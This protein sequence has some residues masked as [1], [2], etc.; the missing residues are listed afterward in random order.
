M[1]LLANPAQ[2]EA[3]RTIDGP[4][5]IISCPGSGK[6]TTLV[7]RIHHMIE[8]GV[9]PESIL[10]VTFT[11]DAAEGMA[12]K[13]KELFSSNPGVTFA[14]IHSLC[15]T[16]LKQEG[17]CAPRDFLPEEKKIGFLADFIRNRYRTRDSWEIAAAA[18][19]AISVLKNNGQNPDSINEPG[20]SLEMLTKA[21]EAYE[22]WR[23][24]SGFVDFD[25]MLVMCHEAL[26]DNPSMLEKY[27]DMF[28]YVQCDEYQDTNFIQ[29]DILYLLT[30]KMQNLCVVGD[31]DQSIYAFRGA[32]PEIM[33]SFNKDFPH[34]AVIR[35]GV[36]Y[37]SA[38]KIVDASDRLIRNNRFRFKKDFLSQ[39]GSE[40]ISG[41]V[42]NLRHPEKKDGM[43]Y[44]VEQIR[45]QHEKGVPYREMAVLFRTNAQAQWPAR[46]LTEA[47][48]PY[49]STENVR[50]IY[51]GFIFEDIQDYVYL[52]AGL[53][54][55]KRLCN[56]LNHPKRYL[57]EY[58]FRE[59]EY[60]EDAMM[61]ACS[62]LLKEKGGS[63]K[64]DKAL[65]QVAELMEVFGPGEVTLDSDPIDVM[66]RMNGTELSIH[67]D[68]YLRVSRHGVRSGPG[69]VPGYRRRCAQV[70]HG[71]RMVCCC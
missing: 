48:I 17:I 35:M 4:V 25:D 9:R 23:K 58:H 31:D 34:A 20:L 61:D 60:T 37:R 66:D 13:Y 54:D 47:G 63:W 2:E 24:E 44:L 51:E 36:N 70:Q 67:Y 3:I 68:K 27:Q 65:D 18:S 45:V 28:R 8:C 64:Y 69:H 11:R 38:A 26:R 42:L 62:Y 52:S 39:R 46:A 10:M 59:C 55:S 14:T 6:T 12:K 22:K 29:R 49:Y 40:G 41:T 1:A 32:R 15:F 57:F 30:A 53:G 43:A 7:R 19:S 56:I 16:I 50:S 21:Y 33:L 5:L 71:P